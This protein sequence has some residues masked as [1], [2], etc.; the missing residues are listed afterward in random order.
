MSINE[1]NNYFSTQ[2]RTKVYNLIS[3]EISKTE[4]TKNITAP[5]IVT[6]LSWAS[7]GVWPK[8]DEDNS[9]SSNNTESL[10]TESSEKNKL[11]K[12]II[13]KPEVHKYCLISAAKS[14]TDFH[15]DFGGS[16][17]WYH[18][19]KVRILSIHSYLMF[20]LQSYLI[21]R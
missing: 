20:L 17:V 19:V 10:S 4:L 16:T 2:P 13:P 9:T 21:G 5:K 14:Y 7:N 11:Q 12:N 18:T 8:S 3:F 15:I 6:E 1:L